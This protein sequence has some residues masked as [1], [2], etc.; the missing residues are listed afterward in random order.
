[1]GTVD[2]PA[3]A[4]GNPSCRQLG[5]APPDL[6]RIKQHREANTY[7]LL[8][9]ALLE[10]GEPM[11]LAEVADRFDAAGVAPRERALLSL[12]RCK[13]ARAPI[14]RDGEH[15]TLD[16]GDDELDLWLFRLGLRGPRVVAPAR[17]AAAPA[18]PPR[19]G[20]EEPLS[21]TELVEAWRGNAAWSS[22]SP[23]RLAIAILDA[24]GGAMPV[25]DAV[26]FADEHAGA[27]RL[28]KEAAQ[29]WRSGAPV[30]ELPDGRWMLD[31]RHPTVASARNA[32]R[33]R[34]AM[35]RKWAGY[36]QGADDIAASIRESERRSAGRAAELGT[37]AACDRA[38]VSTGRARGGRARGRRRAGGS[39]HSPRPA[40]WPGSTR[41]AR[42][43][44]ATT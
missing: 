36:R 18:A 22:F 41:C 26:A 35:A 37:A 24:H 9:V 33:D 31:R 21:T 11:T 38:R 12:K 4:A 32:V 10:R 27:R 42:S 14:Y 13:P 8:I 23:Q 2:D 40:A 15:Y 7:A 29:Y 19:A 20:A 6:A 34:V 1:M 5:I 30:R 25:D 43:S 28:R 39:T 16:L 3:G 44:P 17:P